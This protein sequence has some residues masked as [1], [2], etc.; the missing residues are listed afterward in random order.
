MSAPLKDLNIYL[1]LLNG[2]K[3]YTGK[4][5]VIALIKI[6]RDFMHTSGPEYKFREW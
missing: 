4:K 6:F 2:T 3:K 1:L 5:D